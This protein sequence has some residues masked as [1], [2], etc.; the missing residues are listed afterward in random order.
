[1][2]A[3]VYSKPQPIK[4]R[5]RRDYNIRLSGKDY[6]RLGMKRRGI[7]INYVFNRLLYL[8]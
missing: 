8:F 5:F 4:K 7:E 3:I 2:L 1:M 6:R